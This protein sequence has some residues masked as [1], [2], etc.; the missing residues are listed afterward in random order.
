MYLKEEK[1]EQSDPQGPVIA[2]LNLF[3]L[4]RRI[5]NKM[6]AWGGVVVKALRYQS[7]SPHVKKKREE[8]GL[9]YK[10]LYW[11]IGRDSS[12]SLHNKPL[13]YKQILKRVWTYGIQL[14]G[15]TKQSNIDIMRFQNKVLRNFVN[16]P[17][18]IRNNDLHRDL[19]GDAV[20]SE[21]QRFA[22][23]HEERL[24]HHES[25]EAIELLD[26]MGMVR[27]LQRK[28]PFEIV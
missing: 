11:L 27:R 12:L 7:D 8:L 26:S 9:R 10:K 2:L 5:L 22:Q 17:W 23:K 1:Q 4:K 20:S 3:L 13:L 25:V 21:I 19:E 14:G 16:A 18:C 24:H 15:C 6:G 28:K